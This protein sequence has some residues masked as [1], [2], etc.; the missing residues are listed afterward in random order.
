MTLTTTSV[1]HHIHDSTQVFGVDI[2]L[3]QHPHTIAVAIYTSNDFANQLIVFLDHHQQVAVTLLGARILFIALFTQG[4]HLL[5]KLL[6]GALLAIA[7]TPPLSTRPPHCYPS[8]C[9][10]PKPSAPRARW[11]TLLSSHCERHQRPSVPV[12]HMQTAWQMPPGASITSS[13]S[14]SDFYLLKR[15]YNCWKNEHSP[16]LLYTR[17]FLKALQQKTKAMCQPENGN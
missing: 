3:D 2:S 17:A 5:C 11:C 7:Q 12:G 8:P 4:S 13:S 6:A 14:S 1:A 9:Y 10:Q 16:A 15:L